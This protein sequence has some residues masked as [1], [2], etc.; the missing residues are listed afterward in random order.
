MKILLHIGHPKTGTSSLQAFL[1]QQRVA[2][3]RLGVLYPW[4]VHGR[5]IHTL[6]PAGFV[7]DGAVEPSPHGVYFDDYQ[8]FKEAFAVFWRQLK[9][10]IA[11][12]SPQVVV[13]S[14]EQLF[15][16]FAPLSVRSFRD[17][18]GELSDDV[19]VVAYIRHPLDDLKSRVAQRIK[20]GRLIPNL[21]RPI[22]ETLEYY[23]TLYPGRVRP[24]VFDREA[25]RN[26]DIVEDFIVKY[27]PQAQEL[28]RVP[29]Q[30]KN[31]SL[32][33]VPLFLLAQIRQQ[34]QADDVDGASADAFLHIDAAT[35][36]YQRLG[37][38]KRYPQSLEL[39]PEISGY[40]VRHAGDFLWLRERYGL[41][42]PRLDYSAIVAERPESKTWTLAEVAATPEADLSEIRRKVESK[43]TRSA[44]YLYAH[45]RLRKFAVR[46]REV[47]LRRK[48]Q[49]LYATAQK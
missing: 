45:H 1:V 29:R 24:N 17:L 31:E 19:E 26:G 9:H 35:R 14:A 13:L 36:A 40:V 5:D 21:H 34:Y 28:L 7:R 25:L 32:P 44:L 41:V 43:R 47:L 6:L 11:R 30:R 8:N 16:D 46:M 22:K 33:A 4:T 3:L 42:F 12:Y 2:L 23:E 10:D 37:L 20:R 48:Q 27:L 15:V 49:S 38:N 39:R 18:L